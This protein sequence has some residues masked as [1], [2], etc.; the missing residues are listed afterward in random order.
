[1]PASWHSYALLLVVACSGERSPGKDTALVEGSPPDDSTRPTRVST[2]NRAAGELFAVRGA[3]GGQAFIVNPSYGDAQALDTLTAAEWNVEGST[4]SLLDGSQV[5]GRSRVTG[6]RY[7]STCAG[8]P[9]ATLNVESTPATT[10]WRVAFPVG[11]VEGFAFDSLPVLSSTDSA[12]RARSGALAAS[13]LPDDTIAAFRGRPFTV[14]QAHQ[15]VITPDTIMT[16]FEVVRLVAQEAN[17]LQE[18]LLILTE[19]GPGR[20]PAGVFHA[21]EVGAEERMGSIELLAVLRV[22]SSG[23]LALLV[24]RERESGFM[25]EWLERSPRGVWTVRWRSATD[26]C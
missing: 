22:K 19:E 3:N 2:W 4:L 5:L 25:L 24:R 13:R 12:A 16:M 17:P 15:F 8:W 20:E 9:T 1:M 23:R 6:L 10:I 11:T 18:Q 14:R 21:R 7:D 26:G